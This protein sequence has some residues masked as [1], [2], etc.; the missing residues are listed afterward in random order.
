MAVV[1]ALIVLG[2]VLFFG[3][4][5]N[6]L[7][8]NLKLYAS[9][10][11][12]VLLALILGMAGYSYVTNLNRTA[13]LETAFLDLDM[14]ASEM[15]VAQ[16]EFLLHGIE[17]K[18]YGEKQ[19][20]RIGSMLEAFAKDID[21]IKSTDHLDADVLQ[22]LETITTLVGTYK[23]GFEPLVKAFHQIEEDKEKLDEL[24]KEVDEA[25][26]K[27]IHHHETELARLEVQ[28][29]DMGKIRYQTQI[30][31]HLV[32]VEILSLKVAHNEVESLLDK[33]VDR[34]EAMEKQM[35][36]LTGYLEILSHE[37]LARQEKD[38]LKKIG[39]KFGQYTALLRE[40]IHAEAVVEKNTAE[41]KGMIR[42]I[43]AIGA[44]LSHKLEVKAD[45]MQREAVI[46]M[47]LLIGIAF[48]VGVLLSISISRSISKPVQRIIKDLNEGAEQVASASGQVSTASQSLAEGASEQAASIEETSSSLEEISS[49]TRQNAGN[50]NQA[51]AMMKEANQVVSSAN[52]AMGELTHSM[53]DISKASEETSKI[54]KTIDEIAFQ[55]NLLALNAAVE[56]AR[57]GE[58]GAGFAVVADEVRNLAMRA[59][60]A[61]KSTADLIE[62]TVKKVNEGGDLEKRLRSFPG[63][64]PKQ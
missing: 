10:G 53:E 38:L 31:E 57:A 51:D 25:L 37:L 63:R 24:G 15:F 60:E 34:V 55:T 41:M 21:A 40:M 9:Y 22:N 17:N 47:V 56:A 50:A 33:N 3:G 19:V 52:D 18:A 11:S 42:E 14:M 45:G 28:G 36:L 7:S 2:L 13:H 64:L 20:G 62:G 27:M 1:G 35:G 44:G 16:D 48:I 6:R 59:A 8:I 29:T 26:E 12:L 5:F 30:V 43:E 49:M 58:A 46:A 39:D 23:E 61:A 4:T 54:I 32:Q